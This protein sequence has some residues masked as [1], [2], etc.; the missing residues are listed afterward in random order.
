VPE[1]RRFTTH[2]AP[3]GLLAE[4]RGLLDA[5]FG[6]DFTEDDWAHTLGG[7]HVVVADGGT[8]L[9]HAAVVP[10]VLEV[11]GRPYATGYVEGVATVPRRQGE[12]LGSLATVEATAYLRS[13]FALGALSTA[14]PGFYERFGWERW[15]GPTYV[16]DAGGLVRT[17]DEDDGVMVLRFGASAD[18]DVT[19]P[20]SC[21]ARAGDDW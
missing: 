15:R 10:R 17:E 21:E 3:A 11:A 5:A 18:A 20:I 13:A 2:D 1:V 7:V 19:A 4:V 6:G 12:G 8:V 16:R 9:A 14:S